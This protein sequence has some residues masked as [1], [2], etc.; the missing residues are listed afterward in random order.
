MTSA[1]Y[2]GTLTQSA[3]DTEG[4]EQYLSFIIANEEYAV[5]ILRVQEIKGW[6]SVTEIP[7][8]PPYVLGVMNMRGTIVPIIDL[9]LRFGLKTVE[10]KSTTVVIVLKVHAGGRERVM[11]FVVDA[12]SDV[13]DIGR[14][15]HKP[16]PDFG[17]AVE[18]R[19][20]RGLATVEDKM[21]IL[22]DI[23]Y[24][25]DVDLLGAGVA[26]PPAPTLAPPLVA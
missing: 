6:D 19:F 17:T 21:I 15:Q 11:G 20:L 10:Y 13:Y 7:N 8:T 18:T 3:D 4:K 24:L 16:P 5:E 9:R 12:V 26:P 2:A 23:D 1:A 22:I 25:V 14:A